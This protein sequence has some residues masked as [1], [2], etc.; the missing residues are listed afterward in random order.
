[1]LTCSAGAADKRGPAPGGMTTL[2][3][4]LTRYFV[5]IVARTSGAPR[6]RTYCSQLL[7]RTR[8]RVLLLKPGKLGACNLHGFTLQQHPS[9]ARTH[10]Q[11][12]GRIR[13]DD[14]SDII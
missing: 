9:Q 11:G 4:V 6:T 5:K 12:G 3:F 10:N 13:G 2:R 1:M 14:I 7:P 8:A